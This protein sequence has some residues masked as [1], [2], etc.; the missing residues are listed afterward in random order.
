[1]MIQKDS[2]SLNDSH[3]PGTIAQFEAYQTYHRGSHRVSRLV[4]VH[5]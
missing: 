5:Q 3:A 1:M 2:I 4:Q